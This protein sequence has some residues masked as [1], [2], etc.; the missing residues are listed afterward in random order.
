MHAPCPLTVVTEHSIADPFAT[1]ATDA[2]NSTPTP[3]RLRGSCDTTDDDVP[4]TDLDLRTSDNLVLASTF[5]RGMYTGQF[6]DSSLGIIEND[7][8]TADIKIIPT[9][10]DGTFEI[11]AF[12]LNGSLEISIFN[13]TGQREYSKTFTNFN[14]KQALNLD[15]QSGVHLVKI[16]TDNST[17]TKKMV[18]K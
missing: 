13:L 12:E 1:G 7:K 5:G 2:L 14:T 15:L 18:V 4:I 6:T 17:V 9:I 11:N 16:K 8:Q 10:N 3:V